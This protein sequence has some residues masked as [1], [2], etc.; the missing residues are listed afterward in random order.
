MTPIKHPHCNDVLRKPEGMTEDECR[1]LHIWRSGGCVWSFWKPD[2]EELA[3]LVVG[4]SVALSVMSE[5]HPLLSIHATLPTEPFDR[6]LNDQES[7]A[8]S[9]ALHGRNR[10]LMD[11]AKR[12][13]SAWVRTSAD[14]PERRRL[15]DE[16]LDLSTLNHGL[17]EIVRAV[18]VIEPERTTTQ[19]DAE[20]Y[21]SD[22]EGWKAEAERWRRVAEDAT[23]ELAKARDAVR[24]LASMA[25]DLDSVMNPKPAEG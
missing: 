6:A 18:P 7:L 9:K 19:A 10:A 11:I 24:L 20:R 2:A 4:G 14:S 15:I 25:R 13:I 5:T 1:D 23:A 21:R 17:N 22:A 8:L 16:F 3:A 12:I